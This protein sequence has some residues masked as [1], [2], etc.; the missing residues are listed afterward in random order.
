MNPKTTSKYWMRACRSPKFPEMPMHVFALGHYRN[1]EAG[2]EEFSMKMNGFYLH[3]YSKEYFLGLLLDMWKMHFQN[4]AIKWDVIT[5]YPTRDKG[6]FNENMVWLATELSKRTGVPYR[7]ILERN[8]PIKP[9]HELANVD[10]RYDNVKD[11]VDVTEDVTGKNVLIMDNASTSGLSLLAAKHKLL[12]MGAS[13]VAGICLGLGELGK[14]T[15]YDINPA[16][17]ASEMMTIFKS[18]KVSKEKREA[19]KKQQGR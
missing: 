16:K 17:K 18:P 6:R 10:E 14:D 4:D 7:Q 12:S 13:H 8:R 9:S 19:W 15:D 3:G 11:S 1:L 5:V 2:K